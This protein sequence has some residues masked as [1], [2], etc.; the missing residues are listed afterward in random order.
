[1]AA[2]RLLFLDATSLT[3]YRWA[4][5][6]LSAEAEFA[7][8]AAGL[9]AFAEYVAKARRSLF[10]L[11]ADLAEEGFQVEEVPYVQG[12]DRSALIRR[13]LSQYFYGTPYALAMSLGRQKQGRRDERMLFT[14]LT[15]PPQIEPWL[16]ILRQ[17]EGRLAGLFSVPTVL[18][19]MP[20]LLGALSPRYMV[21]ST[22]R[23]G[24]RQTLI[25]NGRVTFSRL[26]PLVT[27]SPEEMALTCAGEA[28]KMYQ[29]VTG[30][31]LMGRADQ[32]TTHV[33]VHPAQMAVFRETCVDTDSI[34][35]QFVDL[36]EASSRLGLKTPLQN[37]LAE[38][39]FLHVLAHKPPR[40][41]FAPA[42]DRH[43]FRLA[44]IRFGLRTAGATIFTACLLFAGR[45]AIEYQAIGAR[46][47][48]TAAVPAA[49]RGRYDAILRALPKIPISN[50][51]LR[52]LTGRY[53]RILRQAHG[54]EPM[55]VA[56][57]QALQE[58]PRVELMRLDWAL[59]SKAGAVVLPGST[60]VSGTV[61]PQPTSPA[62][63][64]E[65]VELHAQLPIGLATDP[66]GQRAAVD[67]FVEHLRAR[68]L[69]VQ[70]LKHSFEADSA[71]SIKSSGDGMAQ[72]QAP[73]FSL[74]I[75]RRVS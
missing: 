69:G 7:P 53:E 55:Y 42:E 6:H 27:G 19:G 41:Q 21:L 66:R 16:A 17:A 39:L 36:L 52:A 24:V 68:N 30:Q 60:P 3:A 22:T 49:E 26:T 51:A 40:E 48:E 45:Q 28:E 2:R 38:T 4:G 23:A 71:K 33:L 57:S 43:F 58:S 20:L 67:V 15:R 72:V 75:G 56:I 64:F 8:D 59:G 63:V 44:Q 65:S 37:T 11:L 50:D 70:V 1:M 14:A 12:S 9:E 13:K 18:A 61:P 29:Y 10:Y 5:G 35:F 74:R 25:D 47:A 32:M 31:R 73:Q 34:H 46:N 54:P 62:D